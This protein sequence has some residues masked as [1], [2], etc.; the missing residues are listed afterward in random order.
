M[1]HKR[2]ESTVEKYV[3]ESETK[4]KNCKLRWILQQHLRKTFNLERGSK[5]I[6]PS[7]IWPDPNILTVENN[8][9]CTYKHVKK[10]D[11]SVQKLDYS[12]T[13]CEN[14]NN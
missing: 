10:G 13:T 12:P 8:K 4:P 2:Q 7:K 1:V 6:E 9:K 11:T 14:L 5:S 3:G